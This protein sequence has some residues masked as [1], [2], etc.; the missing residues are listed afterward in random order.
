VAAKKA[1]AFLPDNPD[2][3]EFLT[4][5]QFLKF[6]ADMYGVPESRRLPAVEKYAA[7]YQITADLGSLVQSYS[8]GMKQK[9]S[10]ISA[11]MREPKLLMLDEP[12]VGLDPKAAF[13]TKGFMRDL[14]ANGGAVFF[15]SHVLDVVEKLCDKI[16]IIKNG[17][18]IEAGPTEE[19]T[20]K[21]SLESVFL[22]LEGEGEK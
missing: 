7:A 2:I 14:C 15:S 12:F 17:R 1:L 5:F 6:I 22:E 19:I 9:L 16:A 8:H 11:F 4:G 10:L 18:L 13:L 3:Y 21:K 20:G